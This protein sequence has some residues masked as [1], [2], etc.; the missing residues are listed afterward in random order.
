[1]TIES[2]LAFP[3]I[4][5]SVNRK[6]TS[7]QKSE[8][9]SSTLYKEKVE[10]NVENKNKAVPGPVQPSPSTSRSKSKKK[11]KTKLQILT[12]LPTAHGVENAIQILLQQTG[13]SVHNAKPSGMNFAHHTFLVY[14]FASIVNEN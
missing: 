11:K 1:M 6:K 12:V 2:I 13:Y 4:D 9:L 3:H 14:S 5:G 8:I 7:S 10:T